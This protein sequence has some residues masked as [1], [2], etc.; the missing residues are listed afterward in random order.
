MRHA[1]P[2]VDDSLPAEVLR[3]VT[4]AGAGFR[5]SGRGL[6]LA[7][8]NKTNPAHA[9]Y[10]TLDVVRGSGF[11]EEVIQAVEGYDPEH[12]A[13]LFVNCG[14]SAKLMKLQLLPAGP[15]GGGNLN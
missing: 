10:A 13:V 6:V 2:N 3:L 9:G 5:V 12:E 11:S 4:I 7:G 14:G 8:F 15:Q 1:L